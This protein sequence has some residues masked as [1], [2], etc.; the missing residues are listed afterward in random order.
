MGH[1][2]DSRVILRIDRRELDPLRILDDGGIILISTVLLHHALLMTNT[3]DSSYCGKLNGTLESS[4]VTT[5]ETVGALT[6][7]NRG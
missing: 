7:R 4:A 2:E 6:E 5:V 3:G 1:G